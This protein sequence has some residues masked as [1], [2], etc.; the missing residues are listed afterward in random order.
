MVRCRLGIK[1]DAQAIA[2]VYV[3]TWRSAYAGSLPDKVLINMSVA[4]QAVSWAGALERRSGEKV[5]VAEAP[6]H[7]IIGVGSAGFNR[8]RNSRFEG[9]VYTLYVA[10]DFQNQG[11]GAAL[12]IRLF[13]ELLALG[14]TSAVIWV[15]YPNP[16]RYFYEVMGGK[17]VGDRNEVLWGEKMK[18]I[19]YGWD[20][21]KKTISRKP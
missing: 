11:V 9:E 6:D 3:E 7:G 19:A 18:E 15:L 14:L 12:L 13:E 2:E 1:T 16:S 17:R 21:L 5:V 10:P 8:V 4:R 20:D